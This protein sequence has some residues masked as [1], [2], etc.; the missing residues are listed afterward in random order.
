MKCST[1]C[2]IILQVSEKPNP[3]SEAVI[4]ILKRFG[5]GWQKQ[6]LTPVLSELRYYLS[7]SDKME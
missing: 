6:D 2:G 1:H 5:R 3:L 7:N 4:I